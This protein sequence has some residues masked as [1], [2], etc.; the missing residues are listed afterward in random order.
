MRIAHVITR[1]IIGGAQE[2]TLLTVKGQMD[3]GHEVTLVTGPAVG[4]E[5]D[6]YEQARGW[7]VRVVIVEELCREISRITLVPPVPAV[8]PAMNRLSLSITLSFLR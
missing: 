8:F 4:P 6:L 7:G 3:L 1:L 2:N 5:G